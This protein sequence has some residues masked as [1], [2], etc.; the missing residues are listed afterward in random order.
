[1]L[2]LRSRVALD[3]LAVETADSPPAGESARLRNILAALP[4]VYPETRDEFL[5]QMLNLQALGAID[6]RKGCYPGQEIVA[7]TQYRGQLKRRMYLGRLAPASNVGPGTRVQS[8]ASAESGTVVDA[9]LD[10]AG[11]WH[12]LAVLPI[13]SA[14]SAQ[15][16]VEGSALR[17]GTLPYEP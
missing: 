14:E 1:L 8:S 12:V 7:R 17:I 13:D 11:L 15:W 10:S 3:S 16:T 6:F 2:G 5:P 9:A 4:D